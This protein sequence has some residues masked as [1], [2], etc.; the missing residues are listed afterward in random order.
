MKNI[1]CILNATIITPHSLLENHAV[2]IEKDRIKRILPMEKL[3]EEGFG[4]LRQQGY[5]GTGNYVVPGFIDIHSDNIES[6]VQPRP[7]SAM[8]LDLAIMEHEKQLVNQGVTTMYHSLSLM[9]GENAIRNKEA[10][11]PEKV[12]ELAE[13]IKSLHEGSHL[14]R[15]KFHCR[16]DIRNREGYDTLMDYIEKDY[17][18]LLSFNDHTPG[19]G[20]YRDLL[21]YR[22]SQQNYNPK[23]NDEQM[24]RII[25]ERI[26]VP[27]INEEMLIK[28]AEAA[29]SKGIPL[30]SHDDDCAEKIDYVYERFKAKISEFPI[31]LEVAR[32]AKKKG[33][34]TVAGAPNVLLGKSHSGN[35]SAAE[36]IMDG[37][38]DILCSDYY[39]PALL[40][41][42]F[43]L[44]REYH[45]PFWEAFNL[46]TINP[47]K[48]L[49][50]EKDFGSIEEG[51]KAD[52]L[53][54]SLLNNKP[55]VTMV[56]VDGRVVA[57]L[58]YRSK[59]S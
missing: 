32:K 24:D 34:L 5:D 19:Q 30:A 48:A 17:I 11:K 37:S 39:P 22:Q 56:F 8:R 4:C 41:A 13:I 33:M 29:Y 57:Q 38:I 55:T 47:A 23:L 10:R 45:L 58:N 26:A 9:N 21:R 35:M 28:A 1:E 43:K 40:H 16:F 6:V 7:T 27:K 20:Q 49:G 15:H 42:V 2:V 31:A 52:I 25:K 50:I 51:K 44:N 36:A 53:M 12:K 54:L 14:I 3:N 59:C 18:H 46:V